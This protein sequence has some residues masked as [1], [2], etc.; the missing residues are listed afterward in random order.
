MGHPEIM[1]I[2]V[3]YVHVYYIHDRKLAELAVA[4]DGMRFVCPLER[5]T[6]AMITS[7]GG[8][9]RSAGM[10]LADRTKPMNE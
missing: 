8:K 10:R 2:R 4:A 6:L 3:E 9:A 1:S 7:R 5:A